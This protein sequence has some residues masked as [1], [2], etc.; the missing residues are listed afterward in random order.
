M[1]IQDWFPLGLVG[2]ISLGF[3]RVFFNTTVQKRQFFSSQPSLGL[4]SHIAGKTIALTRRTF[5]GQVMS[6]LFNMLSRFVIAFLPRSKCHLISWYLLI[7]WPTYLQSKS[8]AWKNT[9]VRLIK[10]LKWFRCGIYYYEWIL[11]IKNIRVSYSTPLCQHT[12]PCLRACKTQKPL[13]YS[14]WQNFGW[15]IR[16]QHIYCP[17][18]CKQLY[19]GSWDG[20]TKIHLFLVLLFY[21]H[22]CLLTAYCVQGTLLQIQ[23]RIVCFV[24]CW[25][26]PFSPH[27]LQW[28]HC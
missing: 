11:Y 5:V 22:K 14:E 8:K 27:K 19:P 9:P 12:G 7:S 4:N 13:R 6:L 1:N 25:P 15:H 2:L 17:I 20:N 26:F 28:Y 16:C 3:S 10:I 23:L 21:L 18:C 24:S